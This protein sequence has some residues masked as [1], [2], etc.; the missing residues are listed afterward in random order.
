LKEKITLTNGDEETLDGTDP[1]EVADSDGN[2]DKNY[3]I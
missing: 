1:K 2:T 3:K